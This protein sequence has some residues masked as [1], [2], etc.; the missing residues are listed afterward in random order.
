MSNPRD[1]QMPG[2]IF[3]IFE[4]R[5]VVN[6]LANNA[7]I[8][9]LEYGYGVVHMIRLLRMPIEEVR[10]RSF[11]RWRPELTGNSLDIPVVS[12]LTLAY[13]FAG[14]PGKLVDVTC[15]VSK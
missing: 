9:L 6:A 8:R 15:F 1:F 14:E 5:A 4:F 2:M 12:R 10:N 7:F 13:P 3:V 11:E